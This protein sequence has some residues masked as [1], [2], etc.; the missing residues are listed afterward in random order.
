MKPKSEK[1]LP[2][3]IIAMLIASFAAVFPV[4]A[5]PGPVMELLSTSG[6]QSGTDTFEF[7]SD[8]WVA[9]DNFIMNVT[10]TNITGLFNW[11]VQL[12]WT[13]H[14]I[15]AVGGTI[16]TDNVFA[17]APGG[18]TGPGTPTIDNDAGTLLYGRGLIDPADVVDVPEGE[19]GTLCQLTFKIIAGVSK[20]QPEVNTTITHGTKSHLKDGTMSSIAG[21]TFNDAW[22]EYHYRPPPY[23]PWLSVKPS[24]YEASDIGEDIA[25]DIMVHDLHAG[26]EVVG[27]E[28]SL[29]FNY[30]LI[31]AG[32]GGTK[33]D[34]GTLMEAYTDPPWEFADPL[35]VVTSDYWD[36]IEPG[37][38]YYKC[39]VL[40]LR[41]TS[42][43]APFPNV[44]FGDEEKLITLH[45]N[46]TYQTLFPEIACCNLTLF[47]VMFMDK[48]AEEV[49]HEPS[50]DGK[51]CA[52]Q[53]V[54]GRAIDVYT[55]NKPEGLNGIG[56]GKPSDMYWPQKTVCLCA[57]VTYNLG[58]VQHK[59]VTFEVHSPHGDHEFV[60]QS[61][62]DSDGVACVE[63]GLPWPCENPE[64]E[65]LGIWNVIA[66]VDIRC[67]VVNDTMEFK[68]WW[69]VEVF[70]VKT[71][72]DAYLKGECVE[73]T[74]DYG[75]MS[76]QEFSAMIGIVVIDELG[77]PIGSFYTWDSFGGVEYCEW[78]NHT[79]TISICI[80][81]WAFIG[82]AEIRVTALS[83]MPW[84]GG[85]AYCPEVTTTFNIVLEE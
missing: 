20:L 19:R 70:S 14:I 72:L 9:G 52:P 71:T 81:K 37:L 8:T 39:A 49:S 21:S 78:D 4:I 84:D 13:P 73:I 40:I 5:A 25:I 82:V 85:Y 33:Y 31:E 64:D 76:M 7:W 15:D 29:S 51:Y 68:V 23:D 41:N 56:L 6:D 30:T 2:I 48:R 36:I 67:T 55:C 12:Q 47:D 61:F 38:N 11:Q 74:V 69:R 60:L 18:S 53:K 75:T 43:T 46:A 66:T 58:P 32:Y 65:I 26:H 80:P 57:L 42:Y 83:K 77:V 27:V 50:A 59:L 54:L 17:G 3:V 63:F 24:L 28:F 35:Y 62:S 10:V 34:A 44:S 1:L 22:Y 79:F 45:F 16:P